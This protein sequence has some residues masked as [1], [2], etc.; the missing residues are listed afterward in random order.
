MH[1]LGRLFIPIGIQHPG[2]II[3]GI[4]PS[5]WL[6]QKK[7]RRGMSSQP[8]VQFGNGRESDPL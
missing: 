7:N 6:C 3:N 8:E 4:T 5:Q 1:I 2:M